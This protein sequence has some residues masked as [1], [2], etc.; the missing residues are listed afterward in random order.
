MR[1]RSS[2]L[3][4]FILCICLL[5]MG[6]VQAGS[7]AGTVQRP[8]QIED[9][10]ALQDLDS[11]LGGP[12]AF[13]PGAARL[14]FVSVR[15][16]SDGC[17][18][19][20]A[21]LRGSACGDVWLQEKGKPAARLTRGAQDRSGWWAPEWS[22]DGEKLAML[23]TRGGYARVWVWDA[24]TGE[25][26]MVDPRSVD[27]DR[28]E[29]QA[30]PYS[31]VDANQLLFAV[32]P[33]GRQPNFRAL[34]SQAGAVTAREWAR[35]LEGRESTASV[36]DSGARSARDGSA[37]SELI[38]VNVATHS[39]R[40]LA[41]GATRFWRM[42]PSR[43]V[44]A[45]GNEVG[46]FT[47]DS[48]KPLPYP[49][50]AT[51]TVSVAD[52]RTSSLSLQGSLGADA[53]LRSLRWSRDGREFAFFGHDTDRSRPP[54]L[55][56][57]N[58]RTGKVSRRS[59]PQFDI[60]PLAR[61]PGTLAGEL[62]QIEWVEGGDLLLH[63][64]ESITAD[65]SNPDARRD[66]WLLKQNGTLQPLTLGM[67]HPPQRLW[68]L[69]G[70][71]AFVGIADG[72][73]WRID[74]HQGRV[75][76]LTEKLEKIAQW[77]WPAPAVMLSSEYRVPGTD[78]R[79]HD[80]IV[81]ALMNGELLRMDVPSNTVARI[82]RPDPQARLVAYDPE[83]DTAILFKSDRNGLRLWRLDIPTGARDLL[84]EANTFLSG[85]A[86]AR[87]HRVD[88]ESLRGEPLTGWLMLP[89][90][91]TAGK[92]YPLLTWVYPGIVYG[93]ESS[94]ALMSIDRASAYNMQIP[95]A[96][97]YAV[98]LPSMPLAQIGTVE[99]PVLRLTEGVLPAL[100]KALASGLVDPERVFLMG[101]S[102]GGMATYGLV[103]QTQ[104][105]RAAVSMAGLANMI[106]LYTQFGTHSRYLDH[107]E[108]E[109]ELAAMMESWQIGMGGPPWKDLDRYIRNS[110]V[111]AVDRIRTPLMIVHG[112]MDFVPI[113]QGEEIFMSLYRQNKPARF[114]RYWGE[115]HAIRSPAN[116]VD[117]WQQ[118][119]A[120]FDESVAP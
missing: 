118:V 32:L 30:R 19:D 87:F 79:T 99:D 92:T 5:V 7:G 111:F 4:R 97:G 67:S 76:N 8:L 102:F 105:F 46:S 65:K 71:R 100:D 66:W 78:F 83:S 40:T 22:P 88:Y 52:L 33:E 53:Y 113:Q 107:P 112:D 61:K 18:H 82:E 3:R 26:A 73:I 110:P 96:N 27:L 16:K 48:D 72:E 81:I 106:S 14:A 86:E 44:V 6:S 35:Y 47:P 95:A 59:L 43:N 77:V 39:V 29:T 75:T 115:G 2:N 94:S 109:L 15:A 50:A 85:I 117:L 108:H 84:F 31:W 12:F 62:A 54:F 104:R 74:A 114:V 13:S 90:D 116:I 119:F 51:L 37:Q 49:P 120:W 64:L 34:E 70:A 91:H 93:A 45:F 42:S 103:S 57:V 17:G 98:L 101:Q 68:P 28:M 25:L 69:K 21:I 63:A 24:R 20:W 23:S 36:I 60:A 1:T 56:R 41:T 89:P 58:V 38:M 10:F 9:L 55:Y 80:R 11:F